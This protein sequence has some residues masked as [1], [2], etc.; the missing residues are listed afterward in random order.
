MNVN[1]LSSDT[2]R[3]DHVGFVGCQR[4][5]APK[6]NQMAQESAH[7]TDFRV[8]S[9]PTIVNRIEVFSGRYAFP[10]VNWGPLPFQFPWSRCSGGT[11]R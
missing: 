1:V 10:F 6:L 3:Y 5:V 7:F 8:C 11:G 2:F 4:V 9:F